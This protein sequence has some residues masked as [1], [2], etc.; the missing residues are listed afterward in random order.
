MTAD[1]KTLCQKII[2][3]QLDLGYLPTKYE[4]SNIPFRL[5]FLFATCFACSYILYR[6]G[7]LWSYLALT[8]LE[9]N[10]YKQ[11]NLSSIVVLSSVLARG[12]HIFPGF[13]LISSTSFIFA[14]FL[15]FCKFWLMGIWF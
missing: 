2:L 10:H 3:N 8:Q 4:F 1:Q 14:P 6:L 15:K 7:L 9:I 5:R 13:C 12:V 11:E